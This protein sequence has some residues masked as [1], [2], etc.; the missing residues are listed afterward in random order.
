MDIGSVPKDLVEHYKKPNLN[1]EM[2]DS[3]LNLK[4]TNSDK[5]YDFQKYIVNDWE[6]HKF[7]VLINA[8]QIGASTMIAYSAIINAIQGKTCGIL[9]GKE[10]SVRIYQSLVRNILFVNNI[11]GL[12]VCDN[13]KSIDL[14]AGGYIG[15]HIANEHANSLC[16]RAFD[17]VYLPDYDFLSA[18][19]REDF[20]CCI[21][22]TISSTERGKIIYQSTPKNHDGVI[23]LSK[24]PDYHTNIVNYNVVTSRDKN[25][26]TEMKTAIGS[27]SFDEEFDMTKY[28]HLL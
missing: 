3:L 22:P 25:W 11:S 10:S 13:S 6:D 27:R 15:Y 18:T 20:R 12:L 5:L 21:L 17:R 23:Y 24:K 2:D 19:N 8:R 7:N 16:G 26:T 14:I 28:Y 1:I 4:I 9:V